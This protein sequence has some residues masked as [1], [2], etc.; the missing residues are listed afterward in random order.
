MDT[1]F[2]SVPNIDVQFP[3][4]NLFFHLSLDKIYCLVKVTVSEQG[5]LT[6]F[7][8]TLTDHSKD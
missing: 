4:K 7:I 2:L 6:D 8:G 5:N 1:F 3:S